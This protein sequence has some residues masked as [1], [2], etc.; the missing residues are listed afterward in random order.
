MREYPERPIVG[1][2][3][4]ILDGH[5]VLLVRRG[6][7]PLKGEWSLPG[8]AVEVGETLETAIAREVREETGLDVEVGP[9]IDVLDRVRVDPDGRVRYHYVLI[10]YLC[11]PTGGTL[12]C[13]TDAADATWAEVSDL[14]RFHLAEATLKMIEKA[15]V[16]SWDR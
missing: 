15:R 4:V 8:G 12:R 6:N 14:S 1:V 5:R 16:R 11:R 3:A 10:D 2:G 9:M 13:A 7:E